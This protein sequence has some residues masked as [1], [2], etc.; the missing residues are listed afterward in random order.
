MDTPILL[1]LLSLRGTRQKA[2]AEPLLQPVRQYTKRHGLHVPRSFADPNSSGAGEQCVVTAGKGLKPV[3]G[4]RFPRWL[5]M[6]RCRQKVALDTVPD[7][8]SS[9]KSISSFS[10]LQSL[11]PRPLDS[12]SM[13]W[14]QTKAFRRL[15]TWQHFRRHTRQCPALQRWNVS[16]ALAAGAFRALTLPKWRQHPSRRQHK[17]SCMLTEVKP[18]AD[19]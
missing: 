10:V 3:G 1:R 11:E 5:R 13:T 15:K 16:H 18:S 12:L 7:E 8:L 17:D 6:A 14:P 4:A 9:R 2:H 19:R